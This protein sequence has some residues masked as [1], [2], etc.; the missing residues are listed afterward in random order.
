[1]SVLKEKTFLQETDTNTSIYFCTFLLEAVRCNKIPGGQ[2][3]G[4][5][6]QLLGKSETSPGKTPKQSTGS[7]INPDRHKMADKAGWKS[8][9]K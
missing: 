8:L 7:Q 2:Q 3:R 9:T 1:M 6:A 4:S 5:H